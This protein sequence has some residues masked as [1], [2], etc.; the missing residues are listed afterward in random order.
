MIELLPQSHANI[1]GFEV[2]GDVTKADYDVIVPAVQAQV[3][4]AGSVRLLVDLQDFHTEKAE[5]WG[6]DLHF[7]HEYHDSI[8]RLAIVGNRK[9]QEWLARLAK[10]FYSRDARF[11]ESRTEAWAWLTAS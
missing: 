2:S 11:F 6:A 5:A 4:E 1:L 3:D 9:W 10:P 8:E 7:G